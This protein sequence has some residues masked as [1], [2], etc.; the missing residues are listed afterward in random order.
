MASKS[1]KIRQL[2]S[3][4]QAMRRS[5]RMQMGGGD[6][7]MQQPPVVGA[8]SN[9]GGFFKDTPGGMMSASQYSPW[10]M[11][12]MQNAGQQGFK[13][14]QD[15]VGQKFNFAP[16]AQQAR[17]NFAQQT[18]PSIAERFASLGTGG[19]QRSSYFPQLLSQAGSDLDQQLAAMQEQ[20]GLQEKGLNAGI[21]GQMFGAGMNPMWENMY[22]PGQ[23]A[24]WKTAG[25]GLLNAG[26][27]VGS[28]A[29][30][31]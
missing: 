17:T 15:L 26:A 6:N 25:K 13:G 22:R 1:S 5:N 24:G 10:Q 9:K 14:L 27:Q 12:M 11:Q 20:Y 2:R 28:A 3:E 19:S 23:E 7:Y 18:I 21:Y 31:A 4:L 8:T 29:L 30:M 16:I